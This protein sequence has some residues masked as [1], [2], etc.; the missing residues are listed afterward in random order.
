MD[1]PTTTQPATSPSTTRGSAVP[2]GTLMSAG[3]S[4]A[5]SPPLD[6]EL[7]RQ[8]N[9]KKITEYYQTL[10]NTYTTSY[11]N[12]STQSSS[13]NSNDRTFATT[14]LKPQIEAYNNQIINLSKTLI[15]TVNKDNDLILDQI[16]ELNN[17]NKAIEKI[18]NE[19]K[20]LK[21]KNIDENILEQ[22]QIDNLEATKSNTEDLHFTS[23]IYMGI[24]IL[25]LLLVIG[26]I[27]YLVYSNYSVNSNNNSSTNNNIN[28]I[29]KNIKVNT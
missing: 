12:Y 4:Q 15:E 10:L 17:K 7:L 22:S 24:N 9:L 27:I 11:V 18:M 1:L 21:E 8:Q 29:Y 13:L 20:L 3:G 2:T 6:Y 14:S 28:K 23:Q 26:F 5:C 19:L 16:T 25:L